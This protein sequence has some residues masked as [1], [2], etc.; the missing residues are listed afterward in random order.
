MNHK[1]SK[2]SY[3]G[4]R[5]IMNLNSKSKAAGLRS[6]RDNYKGCKSSDNEFEMHETISKDSAQKKYEIS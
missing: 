1:V 5:I 2:C 6:H 4:G 3:T